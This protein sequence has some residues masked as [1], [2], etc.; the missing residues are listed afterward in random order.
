MRIRRNGVDEDGLLGTLSPAFQT[1][2]I[3]RKTTRLY[4]LLTAVAL[5]ALPLI[6]SSAHAARGDIYETNLEVVLRI[7]PQGGTS[8]I[9]FA[10]GLVNPKGL[11][12]DGSGRLYVADAGNGTIVTFTLPDGTGTPYAQ[13]LESPVAIMFDATG[14]LYVGEAGTGNILKFSQTGAESTFATGTGEPAS[15]AFATNGNLFVSDFAGGHIYQITP[16]GTKTTF[17]TGLDAPAGLAFDSGG[18]LFA[19]EAG[20]GSIL[21]FTPDGTRSS[22]ATGLDRPFGIAF[23]DSGGLIVADNEAGATYR[24]TAAGVRS[25]IFSSDFNTPQFVAIEPAPRQLRNISTRGFV[26]DGDHHLI[27]GFIVGGNAPIGSFVAVRALG[28]SLAASGI[29]DPLAD[30]LLGIRDSNGTLITFNDDWAEAPL[31]QRVGANLQPP[32]AHE[33]AFQIPLGGGS[34]T[35]IVTSADGGTGTALVE[36]YDLQ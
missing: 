33:A 35:A 17:A 14:N 8:P 19:A 1:T 25:T 4:L 11:V 5:A 13:A 24:F 23:E 29:T 15:I 34:Y 30:P 16:T 26:G 10:I 31:V 7:R 32:D 21:K 36:V 20:S 9:T 3:M 28:P 6:A 12:F 22:F 27:A 18:N 2:P